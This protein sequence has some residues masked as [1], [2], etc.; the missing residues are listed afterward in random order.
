MGFRIVQAGAL[1]TVQDL[2]RR[3]YLNMGVSRSGAMD[4]EAVKLANA[5]VGN[6]PK[7][8]VLEITFSGP[9]LE[10]SGPG[11]FAVVGW[12][13]AFEPDPLS[14]FPVLLNGCKVN[15]GEALAYRDG[16]LLSIGTARRGMRCWVAFSGG[17]EVPEVLGS[18]STH[19]KSQLGGYQGRA[20]KSGDILGTGPQSQWREFIGNALNPMPCPD[21]IEH[22]IRIP[23]IL[24]Q[25]AGRF[26]SENLDAFFSTPYELTPQ[27]DRMGFRLKGR[28][29]IFKAGEKAD[30]LSEANTLGAV[31][32]PGDGQP[33][34][35][36]QDAGTTGG[37]AKVGTIPQVFF[38]D[39]CQIRPGEKIL[40]YQIP[41]KDAQTALQ[42]A[43]I[44]LDKTTEGLYAYR[45]PP[46]KAL[47]VNINSYHY[48]VFVEENTD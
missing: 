33:L 28:P 8:A 41:L 38:K 40:F 7:G 18:Q 13:H 46:G 25:H 14:Q 23:M 20:L 17:I 35:L 42:R 4:T 44:A 27:S 43:L 30:I 11:L 3:G 10:L 9:S 12:S 19:I 36:M 32:I 26:E 16:D 21:A 47:V 24:T 1:T 5:L 6:A 39:L 31:Q 37:Y 22:F 15:M 34:I 45:V 29:L 2:G 48:Q